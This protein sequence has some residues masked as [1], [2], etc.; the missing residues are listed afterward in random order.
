MNDDEFDKNTVNDSFYDTMLNNSL[1]DEMLN[2]VSSSKDFNDEVFNE[3]AVNE[4]NFKE[5][6]FAEVFHERAYQNN[7][8]C[9]RPTPPHMRSLKKGRSTS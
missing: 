1:Y 6:V 7:H 3:G 4:K 5:E 9:C 2:M 8:R